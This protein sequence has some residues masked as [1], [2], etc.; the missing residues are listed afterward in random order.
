MATEPEIKTRAGV[1]GELEALRRRLDALERE[2]VEQVARANAAIAAAQDKSYWLDRWQVDL[3][4][5]M[6]RRGASEARA[7]VRAMR[8]V[9]RALYDLRSRARE[10]AGVLS[11]RVHRVRQVVADERAAAHG[12]A[13]DPFARGLA[14]AGPTGTPVSDILYRQLTSEDVASI[15]AALAPAEAA[16]WDAAGPTERRRLAVAFAAQREPDSI[17]H[18][19]LMVDALGQTGFELAPGLVGL[20]LGG[21]L[22]AVLAAA[23]PELEWHGRNP[24]AGALD[25]HPDQAFDVVFALSVWSRSSPRAA[26]SWLDEMRRVLRPTGRLVVTTHGLQSVARASADRLREPEE[27]AAIERALY[28]EGYWFTAEGDGDWGTAFFTP[29]W[30]LARTGRR[31]RIA[32]FHPGGV[33]DDQDLYVLEPQS[34]G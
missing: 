30:L 8:V 15:E 32:A 24:V 1:E 29:E 31:W 34:D 13:G 6:R 9:Y 25:D 23:Y 26:L 27:L 16:L 28:R 2:H 7:A 20:D 18:A 11:R 21:R 3:N 17:Y 22:V 33:E 4:Q 14:P 5:L 10:E 12:G 19:D